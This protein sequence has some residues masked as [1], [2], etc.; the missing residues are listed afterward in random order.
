M[1]DFVTK[2]PQENIGKAGFK[3]C[4][5]LTTKTV[6]SKET[7]IKHRI[8]YPDTGIVL[9]M[10]LN[11]EHIL[12][13]YELA[14]G[15]IKPSYTE[16]LCKIAHKHGYTTTKFSTHIYTTSSEH[17]ESSVELEKYFREVELLEHLNSQQ[18]KKY[19]A[20]HI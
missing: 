16:K 18:R 15:L 2:P 9:G 11:S 5:S 12:V 17:Y 10:R 19:T 7:K 13:I 3:Q 20:K 1:E 4:S 6:R 8:I 14:S